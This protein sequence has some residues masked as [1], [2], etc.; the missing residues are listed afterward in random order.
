MTLKL[1][2]R[3]AFITGGANGI[4]LGIARALAG[5]GVKLALAD[6][7]GDALEIARAELLPLAAIETFVLD[8]RDREEFARAA[9]DVEDRLGPVTLLFNNAGV[10]GGAPV[11][12]LSYELWDWG[13]DINLHGVFNGIRTFLP[14]MLELGEGGY[15]VNTSSG[16]GLV[17]GAGAGV[18]YQSTKFAV[19]G[20][21]EALAI[22]LAD[23]D[24]GVSVLCP[25]PVATNII[26]RTRAL[27]PSVT[28]SMTR[29]QLEAARAK[30]GH[31]KS[32]L[33]GGASPDA[34][35]RHVLEAMSERRLYV[36]TDPA[37]ASLVEERARAIIEAMPTQMLI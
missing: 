31:M 19:V 8:V 28:R 22:E 30:S 23:E 21:S 7:D 37:L 25:G 27:Q 26:E 35:G 3:T 13:V 12:R 1:A 20:L 16:A 33:A 9:K 29:E 15:I 36:H 10:A 6:I 2:G 18:L 24:I 14:R 4:G 32:F 17:A 11:S 34:V 5:A